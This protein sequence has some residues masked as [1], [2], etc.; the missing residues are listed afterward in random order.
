MNWLAEQAFW[1][2]GGVIVFTVL[3]VVAF[4]VRNNSAKDDKVKHSEGDGLTNSVS[5]TPGKNTR[6]N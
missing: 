2:V 5:I 1:I 4:V 6:K 3:L